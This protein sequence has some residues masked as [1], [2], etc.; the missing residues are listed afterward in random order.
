MACTSMVSAFQEKIVNTAFKFPILQYPG[1]QRKNAQGRRTFIKL[2]LGFWHGYYCY[3]Q[4]M[5]IS[6]LSKRA[7]CHREWWSLWR[8]CHGRIILYNLS[9]LLFWG[10]KSYCHQSTVCHRW[11]I[12]SRGGGLSERGWW[13]RLV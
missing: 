3:F 2:I 5:E 9:E 10:R 7:V 13:G 11:G 12:L 1:M 6:L 4:T 8:L